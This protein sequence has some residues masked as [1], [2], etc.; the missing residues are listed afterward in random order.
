METKGRK[1]APRTW[2]RPITVIAAL[3]AVLAAAPAYAATPAI[4]APRVP[5]RYFVALAYVGQFKSWKLAR[6]DAVIASTA[7]GRAIFTIPVPKPYNAFVAVSGAYDDRTFVLAAQKLTRTQTQSATRLYELRFRPASPGLEP[8]AVLTVLPIP[9]LPPGAFG[10]FD[11]IA[12][13]PDGT[14]VAVTHS[15]V[16]PAGPDV[17][18]YSLA[19][20]RARTWTLA[21]N[22]IAADP[23]VET[24]SWEADGQHLALDVSWRRPAGGKC[25]DCI[26][27]LNTAATGRDS[28]NLLADSKLLVRSPNL[29][30]FVT[31]NAA[32]IAPDGGRLLRSAIV[33]VPVTK[34]SFYDRP[35]IYTYAATGQLLR[36]MV[37]PRNINWAVL[38]TSP[39]GQSF[40]ASSVSESQ[41]TGFITAA[42]FADGHWTRLRLPAQTLTATW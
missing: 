31:W 1:S 26:R 2:V 28:G 37:G 40:I 34:N 23:A 39:N 17:A 36:S 7:T 15:A 5:P 32:L 8:Q 21:Q 22:E 11:G 24:P 9:V 12:L 18:V 25:L 6:A 30:V 4:Q 27:L 10:Y 38:W 33:P 13:S 41:D 14:R 35:W 29:H 19:T 3:A 42:R 16:G 20:G